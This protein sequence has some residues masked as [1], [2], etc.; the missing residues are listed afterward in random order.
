MFIEFTFPIRK[1]IFLA[2]IIYL[3]SSITSIPSYATTYYTIHLESEAFDGSHN[4][5]SIWVQGYGSKSLPSDIYLQPGQ[6]VMVKGEYGIINGKK[7]GFDHWTTAGGAQVSSSTEELV[8]LS[9]N[10]D[11]T[12]KLWMFKW[13]FTLDVVPISRTIV[14][15]DAATYSVMVIASGGWTTNTGQQITVDVLPSGEPPASTCNGPGLFLLSQSNPS[16]TQTYTVYTHETDTPTDTYPITLEGV[17]TSTLTTHT[18][19]IDLIVEPIEQPPPDL[20]VED[21]WWA[22]SNPSPGEIV[23]FTYTE[24][25]QGEGDASAHRNTLFINGNPISNDVVEALSADSSR[26]RTF[27]HQW[28]AT[29]G[30][31]EAQVFVDDQW[32]ITESNED[33]NV[34]TKTI[35]TKIQVSTK[36]TIELNPSSTTPS[37]ISWITISGKLTRTDTGSGIADRSISLEWTGGMA[38]TTTDD[39]GFYSYATKVG[40]YT[41]G[42]NLFTA[43]FIGY[44]T[45]DTIFLPSESFTHL[46]VGKI[47][48]RLTVSIS[49]STIDVDTETQI[50]VSGQLTRIDTSIGLEEK[51]IDL[52]FGWGFSTSAITDS[53]GYYSISLTSSLSEGSYLITATYAGDSFFS[54]STEITTLQVTHVSVWLWMTVEDSTWNPI[55]GVSVYWDGREGGSSNAYSKRW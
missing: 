1:S 6:S 26:T 46:S 41:E 8:T 50:A 19:I 31:H 35:G 43:S 47:V 25:N 17:V 40:P 7:Y 16:S 49:P 24:K 23:S 54:D 9:A 4:K 28:T 55:S 32:A 21:F 22:P 2:L 36:L 45:T 34:L 12:L 44:E 20:I 51:T 5:G 39:S 52:H 33:N 30:A 37:T 27:A 48:T 14:Q 13:D 18:Q 42:S 53:N 38:Y 15:G 11:G 29:S 3:L 10:G